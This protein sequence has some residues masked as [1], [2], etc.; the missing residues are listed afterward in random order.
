[1]LSSGCVFAAVELINSVTLGLEAANSYSFCCTVCAGEWHSYMLPPR[2]GIGGRDVNLLR[3]YP[4]W[5]GQSA[6]YNLY[7]EYRSVVVI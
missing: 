3:I 6:S 7:L 4:D 1:M 5:N 2:V